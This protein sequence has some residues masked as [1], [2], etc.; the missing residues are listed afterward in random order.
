[1][2]TNMNIETKAMDEIVK[3]TK[4]IDPKVVGITVGVITV[5][6]VGG[7]AMYKWG[8]PAIK[9]HAK[10]AKAKTVENVK[11]CKNEETNEAE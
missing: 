10:A 9:A 3:A 5:T 6:A 8:I 2:E 7:Y 1:M 11:V 4:A